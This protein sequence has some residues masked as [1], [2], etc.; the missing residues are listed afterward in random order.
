MAPNYDAGQIPLIVAVL[1][2]DVKIVEQLLDDKR[3]NV[4]VVDRHGNSAL[5]H[6]A[7]CKEQL[8]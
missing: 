4:E 7:V 8:Y 6:C 1:G 3:T 5:H 2:G